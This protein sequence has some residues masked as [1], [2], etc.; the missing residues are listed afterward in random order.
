[1]SNFGEEGEGDNIEFT[2]VD[3]ADYTIFLSHNTNTSANDT[4]TTKYPNN[5]KTARKMVIRVD[6]NSDLLQI[7]DIVFTN[8]I[9]MVADKAHR[10][11]R[12]SPIIHKTVIRINSTNTK[13]KVR[14]F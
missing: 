7:N 14:W 1:M 5:T 12:S 10:E 8:P 11:I 2:A 4:A 9:T 3:I 13:I 6:K